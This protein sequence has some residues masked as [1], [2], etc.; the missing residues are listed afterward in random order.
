M[1]TAPLELL[2]YSVRATL[3]LDWWTALF[4]KVWTFL[5][6]SILRDRKK[7]EKT[8]H[9]SSWSSQERRESIQISEGAPGGSKD[10]CGCLSSGLWTLFHPR[11]PKGVSETA[12]QSL[13]TRHRAWSSKVQGRR[14][15]AFELKVL[16]F[17]PAW[18][19]LC[20]LLHWR[21]SQLKPCRWRSCG[22]EC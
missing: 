8:S 18:L 3:I 6:L 19:L 5:A 10:G 9:L 21:H 2:E 22:G 13:Q 20:V 4:Y 14:S 16:S 11:S 7:K 17:E 15:M 1:L 12:M